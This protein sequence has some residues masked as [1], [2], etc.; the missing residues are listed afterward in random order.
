[1][2][3]NFPSFTP[4]AGGFTQGFTGT[5]PV[6]AGKYMEALKRPLSKEEAGWVLIRPF[7]DRCGSRNPSDE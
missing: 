7:S 4:G 6:T 2:S 5:T 1:M 3:F